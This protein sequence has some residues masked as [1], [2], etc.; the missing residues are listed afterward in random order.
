MGGVQGDNNSKFS[1]LS[2]NCNDNMMWYVI[3]TEIRTKIYMFEEDENDYNFLVG[4][5]KV[6]II[7]MT[8]ETGNVEHLY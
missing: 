2:W 8:S 7:T 4:H 5:E 1:M 6:L 3:F